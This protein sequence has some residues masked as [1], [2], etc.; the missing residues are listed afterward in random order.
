MLP[1]PSRGAG[2]ALQQCAARTHT[3][4]PSLASVIGTLFATVQ[5][6]FSCFRTVLQRKIQSVVPLEAGLQWH[7]LTAQRSRNRCSGKAGMVSIGNYEPG[8]NFLCVRGQYR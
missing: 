1:Q 5:L 7:G 6:D 4:K 3:Q 2:T 8:R